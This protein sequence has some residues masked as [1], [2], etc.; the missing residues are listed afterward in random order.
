MMREGMGEITQ[1][2][3]FTE[4]KKEISV[5]VHEEEISS[6]ESAILKMVGSSPSELSH[7]LEKGD[8]SRDDLLAP[9]VQKAV[10][11]QVKEEILDGDALDAAHR[12]EVFLLNPE[13]RSRRDF[14]L[15]A[16]DAV[17]A[18]LEEGEDDGLWKLDEVL[19]VFPIEKE[20]L[21]DSKTQ[22]LIE[23]K[24]R[25]A[26]REWSAAGDVMVLVRRFPFEK[27]ILRE[28]GNVEKAIVQLQSLIYNGHFE[29][30][31][32]YESVM[33]LKPAEINRA[34]VGAIKALANCGAANQA[35]E[36]TSLWPISLDIFKDLDVR[37]SALDGL[38]GSLTHPFIGY[39]DISVIER[40]IRIFHL[41]E[42]EYRT[43]EFAS[44]AKDFVEEAKRGMQEAANNAAN[45]KDEKTKQSWAEG[46]KKYQKT[47][48]KITKLFGLGE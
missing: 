29:D 9:V 43:P 4:D 45:A 5:P 19:S 14:Q 21:Q 39:S 15:A 28:R 2:M 6:G 7:A 11:K 47:I 18:L 10:E 40:Q 34:V 16:K 48:A 3:H 31:Q 35:E 46:E 22:E 24:L 20:E 36:I 25:T 26:L 42:K 1:K 23:K 37:S 12:A 27:S 44:A 17:W 13:V 30:A 8:V 33:D 38:K 41:T 32:T